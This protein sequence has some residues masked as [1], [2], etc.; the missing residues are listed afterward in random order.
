VPSIGRDYGTYRRALPM[1]NK[2][3]YGHICHV[4]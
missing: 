4:S 1:N 3:K 2:K